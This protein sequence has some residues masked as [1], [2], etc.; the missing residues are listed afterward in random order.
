M[1]EE[2]ARGNQQGAKFKGK[3]TEGQGQAARCKRKEQYAKA[4]D[5]VQEQGQGAG[6]K[7]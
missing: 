4:W 3:G 6:G 5:K 2:G 1:H 7:G